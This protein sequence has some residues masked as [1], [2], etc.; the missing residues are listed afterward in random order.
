MPAR[1]DRVDIWSQGEVVQ[2]IEAL[3]ETGQAKPCT[4]LVVDKG[5]AGA[6]Y[7]RCKK[8]WMSRVP[9]DNVQLDITAYN[10]PSSYHWPLCPK[11]CQKFEASSNFVDTA[12]GELRKD[13]WL[14]APK[15]PVGKK[16]YPGGRTWVD[17]Q[18]PKWRRGRWWLNPWLVAVGSGLILL[19]I[20]QYF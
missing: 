1:A 14:G 6:F 19:L 15:D 4:H 17:V 11:D 8:D 20:A 7:P 16:K 13:P 18:K 2:Y 10:G 9:A 12:S 3:I 5:Y